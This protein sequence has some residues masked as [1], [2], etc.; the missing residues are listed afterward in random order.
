MTTIAGVRFK[1]HFILM[2]DGQATS[3]SGYIENHDCKKIQEYG[4]WT[5]AGA[6]SVSNIAV[7]ERLLEDYAGTGNNSIVDYLCRQSIEEVPS[8]EGKEEDD[9]STDFILTYEYDESGTIDSLLFVNVGKRVTVEN[10]LKTNQTLVA[11][12]TGAPFFMAAFKAYKEPITR[13]QD[14]IDIMHSSMLVAADLD[15]YTNTNINFKRF[16]IRTF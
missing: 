11:L 3:S 10:L 16:R 2:A 1:N 9:D 5:F 12:G 15:P 6:G 8:L 13:L 4:M 7:M 14:L